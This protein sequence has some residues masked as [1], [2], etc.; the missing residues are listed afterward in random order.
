MS[1]S[2]GSL[3]EGRGTL[4]YMDPLVARGNYDLRSDFYS[5]CVVACEILTG[6]WAPK[7]NGL[8]VILF[9]QAR[10]PPRSFNFNNGL[11]EF[12]LSQGRLPRHSCN[13]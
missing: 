7:V 8:S 10:L 11:S 12:L 4:N 6:T 2:G 9:S 5:Y 13:I 3:T 1:N